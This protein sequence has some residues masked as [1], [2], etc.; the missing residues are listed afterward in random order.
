[1]RAFGALVDDGHDVLVERGAGAG[2]VN[3]AY[4]QAGAKLIDT[5]QAWE[6]PGLA[7]GL[8]TRAGTII[9]AG[10]AAAFA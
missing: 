3:A 4:E 9:H 1:M 7:G 2:I 8:N 10:V 5:A 6:D